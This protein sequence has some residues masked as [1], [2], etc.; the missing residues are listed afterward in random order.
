MFT[1]NRVTPARADSSRP[2]GI[3]TQPA[4]PNPM[5]TIRK[6][7]LLALLLGALLPTLAVLCG[8]ERAEPIQP[9]TVEVIAISNLARMKPFR[10]RVTEVFV[11]EFTNR[12]SAEFKSEL[13]Q[14]PHVVVLVRVESEKQ[15]RLDLVSIPAGSNDVS[16]AK[17]LVIG[18]HYDFPGVFQ[19]GN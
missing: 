12:T 8:C 7:I 1:Q 3:S 15:T 4:T 5:K 11:T 10:A 13:I 6:Q 16:V 2:H 17:S 19:I 9:A 18:N 14:P